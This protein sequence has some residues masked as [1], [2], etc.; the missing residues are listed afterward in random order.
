[1]SKKSKTVKLPKQVGGIKVSKRTRKNV[2]SLVHLLG[3]PEAKAL[4]GSAIA[5]VAGIVASRS[6]A[7]H[8]ETVKR[9]RK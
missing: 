7:R 8:G 5:A 6:E 2:G 1:M 9:A 3:T 4:M